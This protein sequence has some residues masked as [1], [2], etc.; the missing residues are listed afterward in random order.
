MSQLNAFKWSLFSVKLIDDS[1]FRAKRA[2]MLSLTFSVFWAFSFP[3]IIPALSTVD[4]LS[5]KLIFYRGIQ[6]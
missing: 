5:L 3:L 4:A 6:A 2:V 1:V